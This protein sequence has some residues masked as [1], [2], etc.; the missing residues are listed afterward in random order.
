MMD[1]IRVDIAKHIYEKLKEVAS[2][3]TDTHNEHGIYNN[4]KKYQLVYLCLCK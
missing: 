3:I 4:F 1:Y 2:D